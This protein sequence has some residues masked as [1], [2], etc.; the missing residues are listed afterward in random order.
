MTTVTTLGVVFAF[1]SLPLFILPILSLFFS[2][3]ISH[4]SLSFFNPV[5]MGLPTVKS[6][7][8]PAFKFACVLAESPRSCLNLCLLPNNLTFK[9]P[10][11]AILLQL[12]SVISGPLTSPTLSCSNMTTFPTPMHS[13]CNFFIPP[14][15]INGDILFK[16][17]L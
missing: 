9:I 8:S 6:F 2:F 13:N 10:F 15:P 3:N 16:E 4:Y 12:P 17:S 7:R 5:T 14:S 1:S 11:Y